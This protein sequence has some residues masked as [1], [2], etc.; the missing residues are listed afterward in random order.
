MALFLGS[1]LFGVITGTAMGSASQGSHT[2]KA[3]AAVIGGVRTADSIG[4]VSPYSFCDPTLCGG[5][6][7]GGSTGYG[8]CYGEVLQD[9][10]PYC[11]SHGD[12]YRYG[13]GSDTGTRAYI[14]GSGDINPGNGGADGELYAYISVQTNVD[15]T[16]DF[17]DHGAGMVMAGKLLRYGRVTDV[18]GGDG[19][20]QAQGAYEFFAYRTHGNVT[21]HCP[22][23]EKMGDGSTAFGYGHSFTVDYVNGAWMAYRDTGQIGGPVTG[24]GFTSG[25]SVAADVSVLPEDLPEPMSEQT[26]FGA[27]G[28]NPWAYTTDHGAHWSNVQDAAVDQNTDTDQP[29]FEEDGDG[30]WGIGTPPSPFTI[31]WTGNS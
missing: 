6:G 19:T 22:F 12:L 24:L 14:S 10:T 28:H 26:T 25:Y 30:D 15:P 21:L 23:S 2:R 1:V 17:P 5:G 4:K 7:G 8:Y 16:E 11:E 18:C 29:S 9:G 3:A 13:S 27:T 31:N 20:P